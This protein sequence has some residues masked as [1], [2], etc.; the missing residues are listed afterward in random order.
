MYYVLLGK[1]FKN[2]FELTNQKAWQLGWKAELPYIY[3]P[4]I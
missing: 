4:E 2:I 3:K 1:F